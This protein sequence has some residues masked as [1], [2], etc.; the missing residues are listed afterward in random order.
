MPISLELDLPAAMGAIFV[1]L[2]EGNAGKM[3]E[4]E[5]DVAGGMETRLGI[6][7]QA[8]LHDALQR[9]RNIAIGLAEVGRILLEDGAHG[10]GRRLAVE[11]A[12]AGEH[13][14]EN[15]AEG[16]DVGA[17]IDGLA[18]NLLG[19]HIARGAQHH[20]GFGVGV[21]AVGSEVCEPESD[22]RE[23]GEA[24]VENLYAAIFGDEKIF[25]LQVAVDDAFFVGGGE[26]A[27]DLRGVVERLADG[28]RAAA[29]ALAQGFAFQQFGNDVGRRRR[30]AD[31]EDCENVGMIER[32]GGAGFLLEA[33][34]AVRVGREGMR[35]NFD[36]D[37]GLRRESRAR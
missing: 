29:Q 33:L 36:G 3:F 27:G 6:L 22:L 7:F 31:I 24:E 30:S 32:C 25:R 5:C 2:A 20:A 16:E 37:C 34:Q 10:V 28:Q 4:I 23:F 21:V 9:R 15:G 26:S 1:E 12:L 35:Q 17:G 8:M 11:G 14:V 13:L 19:R 18:A